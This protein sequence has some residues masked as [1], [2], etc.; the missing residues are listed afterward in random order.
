MWYLPHLTET[1]DHNSLPG[2]SSFITL[3]IPLAGVCIMGG[4]ELPRY[5]SGPLDLDVKPMGNTPKV[6]YVP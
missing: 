4:G 5:N 3:Y 2:K 6:K 1:R